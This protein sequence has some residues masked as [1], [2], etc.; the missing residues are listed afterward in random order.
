MERS[1]QIYALEF[2][3]GFERFFVAHDGLSMKT[4]VIHLLVFLIFSIIRI[5]GVQL[6]LWKIFRTSFFKRRSLLWFWHGEELLMPLKSIDN[7]TL[8]LRTKWLNTSS[9]PMVQQS[10]MSSRI[11]LIQEY[12]Y[13]SFDKREAGTMVRIIFCIK[14]SFG[15]RILL[16]CDWCWAG[17]TSEPRGYVWRYSR[18]YFYRIQLVLNFEDYFQREIYIPEILIINMIPVWYKIEIYYL[19]NFISCL[20][21][22]IQSQRLFVIIVRNTIKTGK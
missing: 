19:W 7:T 5:H 4:F 21:F 1:C 11:K 18:L 12:F 16:H 3:G 9:G 15:P 14:F 17:K 8:S 6:V 10:K 2:M 20:L 13:F 22:T